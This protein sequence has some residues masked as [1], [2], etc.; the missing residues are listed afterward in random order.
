MDMDICIYTHTH[1]H[2]YAPDDEPNGLK[3]VGSGAANY[4]KK[5]SRDR[6]R[7]HV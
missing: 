5:Y 7:A 1:T 6:W 2:K 3:H 4:K